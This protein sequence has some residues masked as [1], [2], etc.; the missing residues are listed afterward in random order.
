MQE[1]GENQKEREVKGRKGGRFKGK[2]I[3]NR[4]KNEVMW[5]EKKGWKR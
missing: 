3:E 4:G 2:K 5:E 1:G